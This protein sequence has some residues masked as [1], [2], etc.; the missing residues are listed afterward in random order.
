MPP[1]EK[2]PWAAVL[3][4]GYDAFQGGDYQR[5]MLHYLQASEMGLELGQSNA[6]WLLTHV[7][8]PP[9]TPLGYSH[10]LA[11][12]SALKRHNRAFL[13]EWFRSLP[14]TLT[15]P[16]VLPYLSLV[17]SSTYGRT[18]KMKQVENSVPAPPLP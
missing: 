10:T 17:V 12:R 1:T 8:P 14:V 3:Q 7:S 6:A 15:P 13:E 4:E 16:C 2:G 18:P 11:G 5:A 9:F